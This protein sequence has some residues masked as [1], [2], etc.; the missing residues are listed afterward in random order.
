MI[1]NNTKSENSK[2]VLKR[3]FI[4]VPPRKKIKTIKGKFDIYKYFI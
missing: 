1:A 2:P 4:K 3:I